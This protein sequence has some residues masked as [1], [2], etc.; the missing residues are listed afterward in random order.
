MD[1]STR[2]AA[3]L[4]LTVTGL[5]LVTA[6]PATATGGDGTSHPQTAHPVFT[7]EKPWVIGHRGASGHRP[8]HTLEAYELAVRMGA[9]F[10]EPDLVS[11]KDGVLVTRHENEISGTT[12]VA[13]HPEFADR[14]TTK[15]VDGVE[16][17]GW[18]TEDFTL[19]ELK[20]L[21]A[22]ERIPNERP[23]NTRYDGQFEVATFAEVLELRER[24]SAETGREIGIIPEVKHP[25]YFDGLGLSMEEKVV[26][27]LAGAGLNHADAPVVIQSFEVQNLVDLNRNLDAKVPLVFLSWYEGRPYDLEAAGDQRTYA[28]LMTPDGLAELSK[29]VDAIGPERT[30]V[31]P[32]EDGRLG[33]PTSLVADAHAAGLAVTPYTF[34]AENAFL[35]ESLR[36]SQDP[37]ELGDMDTLVRAH[38]EAGVDGVFS[39]QPGLAVTTR[40]AWREEQ[41]PIIDTGAAAPAQGLPSALLGLL[42]GAGALA[43]GALLVRQGARRA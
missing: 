42:A 40:D 18:F 10:F 22:K 31:V 20:T 8:E 16:L 27:Q 12:D 33:E 39:D 23:G 7:A 19:A 21:R 24:L 5:A 38:L 6:A 29:D 11:T 35:P 4:L 13:E 30:M 26:E 36:S 3:S 37:A 41:G 9:D 1:N 14:R 28:D 2:S 15:T 34:R 32:E 17:T 25:T 43:L